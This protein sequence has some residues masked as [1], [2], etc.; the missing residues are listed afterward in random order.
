MELKH[1]NEADFESEVI[2]CDKKVL[3]DFYA[4]W[5]GPCKMMAPILEEMANTTDSVKIVKLD[6]DENQN[7]AIKYGVMSIPTLI[8]FDKGEVV[9]KSVG[10]ISKSEIMDLL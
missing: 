7:L 5:C 9:N 2:K 1:V 4:S 6:V 10:L 8:V 3:V